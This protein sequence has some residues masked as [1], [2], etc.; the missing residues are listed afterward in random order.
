MCYYDND[1]GYSDNYY[2][3]DDIDDIDFIGEELSDKVMTE[4]LYSA[5]LAF[6]KK[7]RYSGTMESLVF[8]FGES[9]EVYSSAEIRFIERV[10]EVLV[11]SDFARTL[12]H[13]TVNCRPVVARVKS[14]GHDALIEC[15]SFEK[16]ID[17]ALDG[18]NI[19]FFITNDSFF[20]GCRVYDDGRKRDCALSRPIKRSF[21]LEQLIDDLSYMSSIDSFR[22]YYSYCLSIIMDGQSDYDDYERT[23][24]RRR[25]IQFSYLDDIN[26]IERDMGLDMSREK[27]R[28]L[29]EF[30]EDQEESFAVLLDEVEESLSFI[31][32]TRINTYEMLFEADEMMLK[33]EKAEEINKQYAAMDSHEQNINSSYDSEVMALLD[34]PEE[35][36]KLLKKKRGV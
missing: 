5:G 10:K 22:E 13:G 21:E 34:N 25:G 23:I 17:K 14:C 33:A 15:V 24:L 31:K 19:F 9:S 30:N 1:E 36:I 7:P 26:R 11:Y 4:L 16:I 29:H 35:M 8:M 6:E 32:S 18:F 3:Y 20:I 28:Y 2:S 27:E 12:Y